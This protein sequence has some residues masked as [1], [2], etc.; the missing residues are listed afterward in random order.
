M[1]VK[2]VANV[3][4]SPYFNQFVGNIY[5]VI[6]YDDMNDEYELPIPP[7]NSC[8]DWQTTQWQSN[9]IEII[10][11]CKCEVDGYVKGMT[12]DDLDYYKDIERKYNKIVKVINNNL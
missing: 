10:E 7:E 8:I 1:K 5:E 3:N 9:E 6:S 11:G 4:E 2:I 12:Q